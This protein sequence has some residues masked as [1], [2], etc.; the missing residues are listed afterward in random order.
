MFCRCERFSMCLMRLSY[1]SSSS[2]AVQLSSP[3]IL[4]IR[5][6][7]RPRNYIQEMRLEIGGK[8][9]YSELGALLEAF[10]LGDAIAHG[11]L[12]S[13]GSGVYW[14]ILSP[15]SRVLNRLRLLFGILCVLFCI[16]SIVILR[17]R[18]PLS[19]HF[20]H[21]NKFFPLPCLFL[22]FKKL[23]I[24]LLFLNLLTLLSGGSSILLDLCCL[25]LIVLH[26]KVVALIKN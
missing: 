11:V 1:S 13:L 4:L 16:P 26:F 8:Y 6:F 7:R 2:N 3:S 21:L 15:Q 5:F 9:T 25:L 24:R 22:L 23:L 10:D 19:I 18:V 12:E 17:D 14:A 20:L